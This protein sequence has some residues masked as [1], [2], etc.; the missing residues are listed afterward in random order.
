MVFSRS[1]HI[2]LHQPSR[3]L[4]QPS[5]LTS[6]TWLLT[7]FAWASF[8]TLNTV[9]RASLVGSVL[10][11]LLIN[12]GFASMG[13]LVAH[14]LQRLISGTYL[15][16]GRWRGELAGALV[17][18]AVTGYAWL[19][20][21]IFFALSGLELASIDPVNYVFAAGLYAFIF[22]TLSGLY[23]ILEVQ[24][25]NQVLQARLYD[26][27]Q[28]ASE[29][30]A[31]R[32]QLNPH[33]LINSLNAASALILD[34]KGEMA[35][36]TV[37][38]LSRFLRYSLDESVED[39]V[40][41]VRE[42]EMLDVYF[43]IERVRFGPRLMV[44]YDIDEAVSHCPVPSLLLQPLVENAIKH[45]VISSLAPAVIQ[46]AAK[47][48]PTGLDLSVSDNGPLYA[49]PDG[50]LE[51]WIN[52]GVGIGL[53]NVRDRLALAYGQDASVSLSVADPQGLCVSIHIPFAWSDDTG[54]DVADVR[55]ALSPVSLVS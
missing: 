48:S 13:I 15:G 36:R 34:N 46:I 10:P 43:D 40:S 8:I 21:T 22:G 53:R 55:P 47:K 52:G 24:R 6:W 44:R 3:G 5:Q 20:V 16:I 9:L 14:V 1:N 18:G 25:R 2:G 11:T 27:S 4:F 19:D 38:R 35:D 32:Y 23:L 37:E 7:G 31:L 28:R 51:Q 41:L 45:A 30:K 39:K 33:F 26:D 12:I 17:L 49:L 29:L 42:L 50:G 54:G